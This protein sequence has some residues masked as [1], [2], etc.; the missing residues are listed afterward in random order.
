MI[1]NYINYYNK[2]K[3]FKQIMGL[4]LDIMLLRLWV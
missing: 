2:M 3:Y 1:S 4:F